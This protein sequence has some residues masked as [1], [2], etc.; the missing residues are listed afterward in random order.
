MTSPCI[1]FAPPLVEGRLVRRYKRFLADVRLGDG[2]VVVAH[3]GNTGSMMGLCE[4]DSPVWIAPQD[5]PSRKLAWSWEI[6]SEAD[7]LVGI[8]TQLPNRLV[9]DGVHGSAFEALRGYGSVRREVRYGTNSRIDLLLTD[10]PDDP[11]PCY[12]EIKNVTLVRGG[13][14]RFPD[15]VTA[16][17]LKHLNELT[18]VVA[19]GGRALMFYLVQRGD[20]EAFGP[21][22]DIDPAYAMGLSRAHAAGVEILA[23]QATVTPELIGLAHPLPALLPS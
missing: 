19:G 7:V 20:A 6:A 22:V 2:S 18:Q 15:A 17:G 4:P 14:A 13:V 10:H 23:W 11:R 5:S 16:R 21:A 9:A 8:N 1:T 12:V 3:C